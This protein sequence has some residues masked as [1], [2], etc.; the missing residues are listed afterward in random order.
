MSNNPLAARPL[1]AEPVR[2]RELRIVRVFNAPRALV[3]KA[4]TEPEHLSHWMAPHGMSIVIYELDLRPG[5]YW[6]K[7][8]RTPQ[9][10]EYWRSGVY[11]EIVEPERL[12]FTYITDDVHSTLD[13]ETVITITFDDLGNRTRMNFHQAF[14]SSVAE[15]DAHA[16]GWGQA[17][18]RLQTRIAVVQLAAPN[19]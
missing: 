18:E 17:L 9:G 4:W 12:V 14:F 15:R 1:I 11:R 8:M 2:D 16:F 6:R 13:N 10:K 3:F 7:C 19:S 5:G